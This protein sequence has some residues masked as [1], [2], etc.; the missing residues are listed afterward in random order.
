[1]E[2]NELRRIV[3]YLTIITIV[4]VCI[5]TLFK[6]CGNKPNPAIERLENINDSLYQVIQLNNSKTDSL[7][8]K[9]DSLNVKGDTIIQQQ[10]ITNQYYRNETFNI[11]N[12]D[13]AAA[14]KQFRTT[15]K[16]SDS[17]LKAGFYTRTY[18][19][20]SATFQSQLQ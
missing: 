17:L 3:L 14:S 13:N 4:G 18:N 7:F 11:L 20:R 19:L 1:M 8:L 12:S 6:G 2:K 10:E 5:I 15:L 9:I 16:K